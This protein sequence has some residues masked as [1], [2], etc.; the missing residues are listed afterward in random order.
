[1]GDTE[2]RASTLFLSNRLSAGENLRLRTTELQKGHG[3]SKLKLDQKVKRDTRLYRRGQRRE[4]QN[5]QSRGNEKGS[6]EEP[7]RR[8][9]KPT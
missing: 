6:R 8:K 3:I 4:N 2:E 9:I 5:K 1:M 7:K